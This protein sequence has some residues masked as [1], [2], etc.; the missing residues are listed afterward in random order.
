MYAAVIIFFLM[1]TF[2]IEAYPSIVSHG[3]SILNKTMVQ[4]GF[5]LFA[6]IGGSPA[7]PGGTFYLIDINGIVIHS[8]NT[9]YTP[10]LSGFLLPNGNLIYQ[11]VTQEGR[12]DARGKGGIIQEIDWNGKILWEYI[13]HNMH[14]DFERLPN[15]DVLAIVW[16][17]LPKILNEKVRGGIDKS[18]I[19]GTIWTDRIIE[20]SRDK[21]IVWEWVPHDNI[22]LASLPRDSLD[23]RRELLHTNA[24]RYLPKNN[25]FNGRES[26]LLSFRNINTVL[27]VDKETKNISWIWGANELSHQHGPT[28]LPNG[29]ILIFDNGM[30]ILGDKEVFLPHSRVIEM[31]PKSN[32]IMWEYKGE[33][34]SNYKFFTPIMGSAQKLKNGNV[35]ISEG[36]TGRM[37]EISL[38]GDIV[39]EY[40]SPFY[41]NNEAE[42]AIFRALRYTKDEIPILSKNIGQLDEKAERNKFFNT[43]III[44]LSVVILLFI[45]VKIRGKRKTN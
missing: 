36:V 10:G 21:K 40:I 31:D 20:V 42:N 23:T 43:E 19:N 3:V 2:M 1:Q 27:I 8:W 17:P 30:H 9:G 39:W 18:E 6:P 38:Q 35:L 13:N 16:E 5:T 14:H 28:L 33:G 7:G 15:G 34:L 26:V 37:F 12:K 32:K 22:N 29:D 25:S 4:E 45:A 11:G 41:A 44:V 24:V